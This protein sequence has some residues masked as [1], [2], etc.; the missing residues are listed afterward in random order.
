MEEW[1]LR[2]IKEQIVQVGWH[3]APGW[4][5]KKVLARHE[6]KKTMRE[7]ET[8]HRY[9]VSEQDVYDALDK[10][11][12]HGDVMLHS[13]LVEIGNIQGRH[14]PFVNYLKEKVLDAGNTILAIAI[15][16]KG[17]SLEYLQS[18][19]RFDKD[20][21][22]AMGAISTY[23]A[24]QAGTYRSLNPTHSVIAVG[25]RAEEYTA[26]HHLDKTPFA[27]KSPF[28]KLLEH[29]G[30]V[31][32]IGAGINHLTLMHIVED[33]LGEL[34]PRRVYARNAQAVDIYRDEK[35]I[36]HGQYCAHSP[37]MSALR[38]D[39]HMIDCIKALPSTRVIK[40]GA[41]ELA[42]INARDAVI[43]EL[44]ELRKGNSLYGWC[45]INAKTRDAIDTWIKR[46]KEL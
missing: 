12:I 8:F 18:I 34:Y 44:E 45:R 14:K 28:Y 17:S 9:K 16:V 2:E 46:I 22:I 1:R 43:C 3:C 27:E 20:A 26:M 33:M 5:K 6:T 7:M 42:Y 19:S 32:M 30:N 31:L 40:I 23:Y 37:W 13:S 39:S 41:A 21:P 29:N 4:I 24:K 11:D 10:L 25:P 35:C 15:P 38:S 36:Y